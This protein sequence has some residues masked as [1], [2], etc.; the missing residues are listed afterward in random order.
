MCLILFALQQHEDYPLVVIAN[1][2]EY[3]ARPTQTAHWW[4]DT[5]EIFAGRDLEAQGTWLGVN[6]NGR[7]AA[8]TNVREEGI[9]QARL[10]RGNL[11][12]DFLSSVEPAENFLTT[13]EP[14]ADNYAGFN[15]IVGDNSGLFFYSNRHAGIRRIQPGIY[16]VSN[17]LF[18]EAWPKLTSGKQAL[19][20]TLKTSLGNNALMQILTD[21]TIAEDGHLPETGVSLDIERMLS[22]RF[23]RS[24]EYGTRACSI[25]KFTSRGQII[26]AEQNYNSG[27][28]VNDL[29]IEEFDIQINAVSP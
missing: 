17:G 21:S 9:G 7:F 10:S 12:R 25:V 13:L 24:N 29:I 3:Y 4:S 28:I 26:F 8:V 15:L 23:I 5:P 16:G 20:T 6:K 1:R 19:T 11:T 22:S 27:G 2:D 14:T 18:D